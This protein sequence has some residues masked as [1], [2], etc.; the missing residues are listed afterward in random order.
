MGSA[1]HDDAAT[2]VELADRRV[3][4]IRPATPADLPLVHRLY[5]GLSPADRQLRF[6][7]SHL[8][9]DEVVRRWVQYDGDAL[10]LVAVWEPPDDAPPEVVAEAGYHVRADGDPEFAITVAG[11]WRGGLAEPLLRRLLALAHERGHDHLV[12]ELLDVNRP[13]RG[14][15]AKL[16]YATIDHPDA[17]ITRVV[18]GTDGDTPPWPHPRTGPRV[19]VE[20]PGGRW[21]AEGWARDAGLD[22]VVCP[23][24]GARRRPCPLLADGTCR[25][26]DGADVIVPALPP[27][28]P[29]AA[30]LLERHRRGTRRVTLLK[31][32]SD[33]AA[34]LE[35]LNTDGSRRAAARQPV[36]R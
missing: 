28:D 25:L 33:R 3:V 14:L 12:A 7:T 8:P 6:F 30:A 5:E 10:T 21:F 36:V 13:M 19:L 17:S 31:T 35:A 27:D 29:S 18:V 26:V 1:R 9:P 2:R 32:S 24:P 34:L 15:L 4:T 22:V 11:G 20:V 16:G 23:G